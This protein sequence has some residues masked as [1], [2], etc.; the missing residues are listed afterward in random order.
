M[1]GYLLFSAKKMEREANRLQGNPLSSP[2]KAVKRTQLFSPAKVTQFS[3][4][5]LL[6]SPAKEASVRTTTPA[7]L[8]QQSIQDLLFSPGKEE[9]VTCAA[10]PPRQSAAAACALAADLFGSPVKV[11]VRSSEDRDS[12]LSILVSPRKVKKNQ[13]YFFGTTANSTCF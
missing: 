5:D 11:A 13:Y 7:K 10:R 12:R 1:V 6:S 4:E 9:T 3:I 2:L 8:T